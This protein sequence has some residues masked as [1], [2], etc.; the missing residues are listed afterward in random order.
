MCGPHVVDVDL[1]AD[2]DLAG[3]RDHELVA[4][5]HTEYTGFRFAIFFLAEYAGMLLFAALAAVL[6]LG[7]WSPGFPIDL[8]GPGA[9]WIGFGILFAKMTALLFVMIWVRWSL[10]R[11]R[12]DK[13]MYLCYKVLLPWS[14]VCIIGV[15]FQILVG[16]SVPGALG[17]WLM[18]R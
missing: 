12:I 6:F 18:G 5:F 16:G 14:I 11:F 9:R 15:A 17:D 3:C 2:P 13:V 8:T 7:G 1:V 10:P 4:G